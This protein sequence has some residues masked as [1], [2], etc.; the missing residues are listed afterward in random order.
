MFEL[1]L[2]LDNDTPFAELSKMFPDVKFYRWCNSSVDYLVFYGSDYQLNKVEEA[3]P[4]V[5]ESLNSRILHKARENDRLDVMVACRCTVDNSTIRMI[6]ANKCLWQAPVSYLE[7]KEN[8]TM[9]CVDEGEC[10]TAVDLLSEHGEVQLV[11][12]KR[13]DPGM[14]QESYLIPLST[15]FE[16]LTLKQLKSLRTA[17]ENDFFSEPKKVT[18]EDL[19]SIIGVSKSTVQEHLSKGIMKIFKSMEPYINMMISIKETSR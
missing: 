14:L 18:I 17:I 19:A 6:E 7:G 2:R 15:L 9:S 8:V 16:D 10:R 5:V 1:D 4:S 13:I 3:L 11:K 12:K